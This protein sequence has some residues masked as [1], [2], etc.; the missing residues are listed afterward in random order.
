MKYIYHI[1]IAF[2]LIISV[3]ITLAE[4]HKVLITE[5][6]ALNSKTIDDEDGDASDWIE[7]YNPGE[8][9]HRVGWLVSYRQIR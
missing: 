2:F 1:V 9:A 6:M 7:L 5:F 3:K 4:S 8:T